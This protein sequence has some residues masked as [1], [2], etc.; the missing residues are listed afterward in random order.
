MIVFALLFGA[1]LV[2]LAVMW[3]M[4]ERILYQPPRF[5][6]P[7]KEEPGEAPRVRYTASDGADLYGYRV[8][9]ARD[10]GR[11]VLAFHGNAD[12]AYW[13]LEW[14]REVVR[15]TSVP[16]FLAEFRG[17]GGLGGRPTYATSRLDARA[18]LDAATRELGCLPQATTYFGHSLGSAIAA[19]LA[20]AVNPFSLVLQSPFT[21][22][23]EMVSRIAGPAVTV[24]PLVSRVHFDTRA[25]VASLEAPVFVSH[26]SRDFII[27]ARMGRDV[28]SAAKRKGDLLVID[29][30]G[31]NDVEVVGG[32]NYWKWLVRGI[33][34]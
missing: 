30:A 21:S 18:A 8:G 27:P 12:L 14:A 16:V 13:R 22:A 20:L 5:N 7:V 1:L 10:D 29:G 19:E 4:Q 6:P 34:P 26:G 11:C 32:E 28:Y 25:N 23:R 24:W 17:Y 15:R 3:H 2:V 31:H 9:E 33:G